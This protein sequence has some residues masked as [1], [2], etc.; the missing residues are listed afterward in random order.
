MSPLISF[1][2]NH[3]VTISAWPDSVPQ[4][5][6]VVLPSTAMGRGSSHPAP[7]PATGQ[8][9]LKRWKMKHNLLIA[10][11]KV[12]FHLQLLVLLFQRH[13][14]QE[15]VKLYKGFKIRSMQI[16]PKP[17]AEGKL[18]IW[19]HVQKFWPKSFTL[20]SLDWQSSAKKKGRILN[21]L[22]LGIKLMKI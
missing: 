14:R 8:E 3:P 21:S 6:C 5:S 4:L 18:K 2:L 13:W 22:L 17:G 16:P 15:Q 10:C 12:A 7:L 19:I 20:W 1:P 9:R 11:K